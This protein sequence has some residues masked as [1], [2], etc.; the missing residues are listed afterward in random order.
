M[1]NIKNKKNCS[2]CHACANI[3]PKKCITMKSDEEGFLY[4]SV[5]KDACVNCGLCEKVCHNIHRPRSK[6]IPKPYACYNKDP[7]QRR[8]S[9]SGGIFVLIAEEILKNGGAVFGAGFDEN[10]EVK[11]ICVEHKDE[12][13]K[14]Q[15]SKYVQSI[16]GDTYK[17]AKIMLD[18]GRKIL[19]S[20]TPCQ[21]DGLKL[22]LGKEYENL[23]T[24]DMICHGVPS[25]EVWKKYLKFQENLHRSQV[26][27]ENAPS[28]RSKVSGWINFS[29]SINFKNGTNY[30]KAN[31]N[32]PFMRSFLTDLT[33]RPSCY[34]C[35]SKGIS[36][37][38]DITLADFWGIEKVMPEMYDNR[39][40]SLVLVNTAKGR[41]L[42]DSKKEFM[43]Y[44]ETD[45][46]SAL[47]Y[48][49][50]VA[51]SVLKPVKRDYFMNS[52]DNTNIETL[53][54]ECRE[55]NFFEIWFLRA[56]LILYVI[57]L[58]IRAK[59]YKNK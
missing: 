46:R 50:A 48:N 35:V 42:F 36:R 31:G 45:I 39:G 7:E 44:K 8:T 40:T 59:I 37:N 17:K 13:S 2:G 3:C 9:S 55:K 38:S 51:L 33:L 23:Y 49:V 26:D 53:L 47:R 4:P 34:R 29:M 10:V 11:H 32:D 18:S 25:P 14:L 6:N 16:I 5:D 28:F 24:C 52:L 12:L 15:G 30:T 20:G 27:S 19:F 56:K 22:Y 43:V 58:S 54:K 57:E 41:E 1:I 21:I